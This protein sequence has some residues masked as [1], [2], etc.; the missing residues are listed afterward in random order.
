MIALMILAAAPSALQT[1][2]P[3]LPMD[4][5]ARR[6]IDRQLASP[7]R[8]GPAAGLSPEEADKINERYLASI[9]ARLEI[10][11]TEQSTPR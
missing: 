5:E 2:P 7:P 10:D 8:S 9:G 6:V 3:P 4:S 1:P 11:R